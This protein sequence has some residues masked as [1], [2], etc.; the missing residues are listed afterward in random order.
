[1]PDLRFLCGQ[2]PKISYLNDIDTN[3]D[4]N[5]E[6]LP[7]YYKRSMNLLAKEQKKMSRRCRIAKADG[8]NLHEAK[9]YQKQRIKVAHIHAHIAAQRQ[10]FLNVVSK[11]EVKNHDY[12]FFEDVSSKSLLMK[13]ANTGHEYTH[14]YARALSDKSWGIFTR[15]LTYKTAAYG[16]SFIKV[17]AAGT[18]ETCNKCGYVLQE[19][20]NPKIREWTCPNCNTVL[21]REE[22]AAANILQRGL[23]SL[24]QV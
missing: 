16:K 14:N 24:A 3:S 1:M 5:Y 4:G 19:S 17:D 7:D 12:L 21:D 23:T 10:D 18:T 13:Y 8:K 2:N 15:M 22:N 6:T 9:N 20:L 11:R